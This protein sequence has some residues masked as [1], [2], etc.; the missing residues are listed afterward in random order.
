MQS[1]G[2]DLNEVVT[3]LRDLHAHGCAMLTLV[4]YL[5]PSLSRWWW[6]FL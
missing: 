6:I 3:V 1:L 4:Q 5:Q 2:E